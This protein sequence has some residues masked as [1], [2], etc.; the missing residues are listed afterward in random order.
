M[1]FVQT[2][3]GRDREACAKA[4]PDKAVRYGEGMG[5][6]GAD[7]S[8]V[9]ALPPARLGVAI[10]GHRAGHPVFDANRGGIEAALGL[11]VDTMTAVVARQP[12]PAA[13]ARLHSLLANGV[14]LLAV[15]HALRQ[16]WEV[17]APLPFGLALNTAINAHPAC[18][19]DAEALLR[20]E[21]CSDPVASAYAERARG[22]AGRA[23]RFELAECDEQV[24]ALLLRTLR[25]PDDAFAAREF[26]AIASE[27]A[28]MAGRVMIEQS[29]L[30]VAIWDGTT[31]GAIGGTRHTMAEALLQG[32][33]VVW[34]DA[35]RPDSIR[36]L[37]VPEALEAVTDDEPDIA[38]L[39]EALIR[40]ASAD[41]HQR[42]IRYH[43][44]Q[45]HPHS[46]RR[47]HGYRRIETLFGGGG[48]F[49]SLIQTYETPEGIGAGSGAALLASA[50]AMAADDPGLV[51]RIESRLLQ[52]FARADGLS[53]YLSDAYR[54]G[55]IT[56]FLL[57]AVAIV[58]GVAYLPFA[59]AAG[60][61]PFA[62]LE[63][64]LLGMIVAITVVGRKHRW[65][66][67]W[68]E[69]R[70]VAEYLRHAPILVLLGVMRSAGRWPRGLHTQWPE[71]Y[72]R[73]TL[74]GLGLP[75]VSL[76]QDYL[77]Q[78]LAILS[79]HVRGQRDYHAAKAKRLAKVHHNLDRLSEALFALAIVSVAAYLLLFAGG[80]L[81][82]LPNS[83]AAGG[84]KTF[85]FLGVAF[86]ALGGAFAGIRYFGDFERFA[87]ISEVTAEKL[88]GVSQRIGLLTSRPGAQLSY[89]QVA[90]LAH[91]LDDIVIDEIE[92]WQAVFAGKQI[93]V[94][95]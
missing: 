87:A 83:I 23:R 60:K 35:A 69:T 89:G 85:T 21:A 56:N 63:F 67:R 5:Y 47:F 73:Q 30:L 46:H 4:C 12:Q 82:L 45:W 57:S 66:G 76:T 40:P 29:D 94:P 92:S 33:P 65:H 41:Q 44:E 86:P 11:I 79:G 90:N 18:A 34:L 43:T 72:V 17:V 14:D 39:I 52:R 74:T 70:R 68:F 81:G 77:R 24:A 31:P 95:V 38:A 3:Q 1:E 22:L 26:V 75:R 62:L 10:T 50:Q 7:L 27:R 15:D 93:S 54:G 2:Q 25:T 8:G 48:V 80:G 51:D 32:V 19:D 49:A 58:A 64:V 71:H 37:R 53:T 42:A 36:L 20:G 59:S 61:W 55:M 6:R 78:G 16:G 84:S 13:P 91:A 9:D 88:E 28:A